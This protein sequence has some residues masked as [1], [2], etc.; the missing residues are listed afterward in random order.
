MR[1]VSIKLAFLCAFALISTPVFAQPQLPDIVGATDK[2]VNIIS[3][4]CQYEGLKSIAVQRSG[5]SVGNYT[6]IG[7]VK[8]LKKGQQAF[9]DGHPAPGDNWYRLIINFSS[10]LNWNSN[11]T[12][13]YVDSITLMNKAVLPPNDSLQQYASKIEIENGTPKQEAVYLQPSRMKGNQQSTT[14]ANL[15]M[16]V[17]KQADINQVTYVKSQYVFTNPFTGNVTVDLPDHSRGVFSIKFYEKND[18]RTPVLDIPRLK[19]K[20]VIIDKRNFR[21]KGIYKFI[22][23]EGN[24]KVEDGYITIY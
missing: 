17:P 21:N 24:V 6:T 12:K 14:V 11:R 2:G 19:D 1:I 18:E 3:W 5:D 4:T 23:M 15:K 16:N 9:I 8:N 13:I 10:D 7:Y 20:E 22:L